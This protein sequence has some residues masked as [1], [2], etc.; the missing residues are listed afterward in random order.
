MP[1]RSTRGGATPLLH[2]RGVRRRRLLIGRSWS[3]PS[4][5]Q[6][7]GPAGSSCRRPCA[8]LPATASRGIERLSTPPPRPRWCSLWSAGVLGCSG[9]Y[10]ANELGLDFRRDGQ[11]RNIDL[12]AGDCHWRVSVAP[13]LSTAEAL[14]RCASTGGKEAG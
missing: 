3:G 4:R 6:A 14:V 13:M 8:A 7:R 2:S 5:A 11:V 1:E 10:R 9:E 12:S